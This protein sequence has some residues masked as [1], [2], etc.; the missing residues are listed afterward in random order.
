MI[1]FRFKFIITVFF[2]SVLLAGCATSPFKSVW[3]DP[4][5]LARPQKVMVIAV[6]KEPIYRRII[7]DEFVLQFKLRGVDAMASYTTLNDK[8]QNDE[9]EIE[10]MVK[11]YGADSVLITRLVS[12]R[13]VRVY[14]PATVI[15]RPAYYR[16]WPH[17]YQAGY[18]NL[19]SP[20]YSTKYEYALMEINLY[21][22]A[23]DTLVWAATTETGVNNLNQTL[24]KPYIGNIMKMM[25]DYGL[26]RE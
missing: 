21:D 20:G 15:S 10:K 16:K 13:S 18:E 5:Y 6:S 23:T 12:K 22:V 11:Q 1:Q 7:E 8:H 24:I 26:V 3:K 25:S 2:L 19:Y 4:S 14:Y 17:Y 9:A